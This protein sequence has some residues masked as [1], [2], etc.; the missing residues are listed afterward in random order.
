MTHSFPKI[1]WQTHNYKQ[2]WLP[3]HLKCV[4]SAW[5]NLNP[6]WEYKYV[7]QVQRDSTVKKY[8]QI[9]E[10]YQYQ[11]PSIQSDIWRFLITYE[12]GGCYA[13]MDS[14]P[15]V[16]LD[17]MIDNIGQDPEIITVPLYQN[18]GNTHNYIVKKDSKIMQEIVAKMYGWAEESQ[19]EEHFSKFEPFN[20]FIKIVY[21]LDNYDKV[22]KKFDVNHTEEYKEAFLTDAYKIN[23]HGEIMQYTDF[24]KNNNLKL[25]YD[26]N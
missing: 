14:V 9:Y 8:P 7:D 24:V 25:M 15:T 18:Q 26:F 3:D 21:A 12:E 17:Y 4:S 5:I 13:D 20:F 10:V 6:G 16:A 19:T 2:K 23:D 11:P 1:I 22:S